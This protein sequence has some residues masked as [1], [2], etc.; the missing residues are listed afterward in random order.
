MDPFHN[1][2]TGFQSLPVIES[3]R[4]YTELR[5][6]KQAAEDGNEMHALLQGVSYHHREWTQCVL[7]LYS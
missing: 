4:F 1:E 7:S 5:E 3:W 2:R 6:A